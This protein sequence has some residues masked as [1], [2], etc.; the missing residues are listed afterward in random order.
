[1]QLC[2]DIYGP[3]VPSPHQHKH[4]GPVLPVGAA[5]TTFFAIAWLSLWWRRGSK[6][7]A[8]GLLTGEYLP[9]E[10]VLGI[11]VLLRST[12]SAGLSLLFLIT[13]W[14]MWRAISVIS[15]HASE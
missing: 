13:L 4:S 6:Q 10:K 14:R 12:V 15:S 3:E 9:A 7:K 2:A 11:V 1:M 5:L 8:A